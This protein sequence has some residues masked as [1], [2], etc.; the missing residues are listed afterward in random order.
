ML[1]LSGKTYVV[2]IIFGIVL[3]VSGCN[4]RETAG[5]I[6]PIE[7]KAEAV[8]ATA[9]PTMSTEIADPISPI[10]PVSPIKEGSMST[11]GDV[12]PIKGSEKAIA[13]AVADLSEKTGV[14]P[15]EI[16]LVSVEAVEWSDSSLGCPQEGFMYAQ[17]ITPGYLI[18]LEANGEQ[19][20][21]HT[22][23]QGKS[24]VLCKD[25]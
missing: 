20:T 19:F 25:K 10:S 15:A 1:N 11:T 23:Q 22:D 6:V 24:I 12:E 2:I 3:I 7:P 16:T 5:D 17:V 14:P 8:S 18:V 13:A 21:Y 9:S 4:S